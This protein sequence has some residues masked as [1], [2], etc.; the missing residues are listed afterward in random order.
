M[1]ALADLN[2]TR[3]V[4]RECLALR[5]I[6]CGHYSELLPGEAFGIG[7]VDRITPA[8]DYL[9]TITCDEHS[10]MLEVDTY[11]AINGDPTGPEYFDTGAWNAG[12]LHLEVEPPSRDGYRQ[13]HRAARMLLQGTDV[14]FSNGLY[15]KGVRA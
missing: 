5:K 4:F 15:V 7:F 3:K 14:R 9:F 13:L 12:K 6:A 10:V 2:T 1:I 11:T 8:K